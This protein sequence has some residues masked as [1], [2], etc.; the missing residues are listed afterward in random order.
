MLRIP[1]RG[2][3]ITQEP[4]VIAPHLLGVNLATFRRRAFAIILDTL[5]FGIVVGAMFT[6]LL[7]WNF[8]RQDPTFFSRAKAAFGAE[9]SEP[10]QEEVVRVKADFLSMVLERCPDAYPQDLTRM[11]QQRDMVGLGEY[12]E[13]FD[14]TVGF[15][16]GKTRIYGGNEGNNQMAIGTDLLMGDFSSVFGWGGMFVGW[17]T[18][19]ALVTRGRSPGKLLLRI[20]VIKLDGKPLRLWDC[21]SRAAGY[22][23]STATLML[24]FM[25][26]IWHPNR[27]A[28]HDKIAGTVVVRR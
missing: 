2:R 10:G 4:Q 27:Q 18:L 25:E 17:F 7:A 23:A 22:G 12:F 19:W 14:T 9:D 24:G 26:A 15:G 21:F 5:L 13:T 8:H 3:H 28:I 20:R 1:E 6:G 16:S 11:V